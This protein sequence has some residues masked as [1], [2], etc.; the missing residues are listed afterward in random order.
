MVNQTNQ[1]E[2]RMDANDLYREE[3]ISDRKIGSIQRLTPLTA[4]GEEDPSRPVRYIGQAQI[5]TQ[6]GPLP[7]S[8]ELEAK[9]LRE[10]VDMFGPAA[11]Q[12][13]EDTMKKLQEMRREAASSIVVPGADGGMGG[14]GGMPGGGKIQLR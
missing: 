13:V 7:L 2:T 9:G 14:M 1:P 5:Y 8:F 12:A 3:I 10:A 6:A 11:E 4:D